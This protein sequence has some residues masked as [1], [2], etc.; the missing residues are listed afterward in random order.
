[1]TQLHSIFALPTS[2]R[3]SILFHSLFQRLYLIPPCPMNRPSISTLLLLGYTQESSGCSF[4]NCKTTYNSG[5][6]GGD[7][8]MS[9]ISPSDILPSRFYILLHLNLLLLFFL[10][11]LPVSPQSTSFPPFSFTSSSTS[12]YSTPLPLLPSEF[13]YRIIVKKK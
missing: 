2:Y 9:S 6:G 13:T 11:Y 3:Y 5:C 1:M 7:I 4:V 10:R 12:S 8:Y